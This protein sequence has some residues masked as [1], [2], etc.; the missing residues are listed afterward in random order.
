[1][2]LDGGEIEPAIQRLEAALARYPSKM[3]LVYDY[4][5]ALIARQAPAQAAAF[6]E[7]QLLR[8]PGDG[9]LH[10]HRRPRPTPTWTSG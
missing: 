6:I 7:T 2:L 4:P 10:R 3:Q 5:E 9:R 8:F 1:M